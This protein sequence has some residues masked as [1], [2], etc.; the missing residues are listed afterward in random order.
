MNNS[1]YFYLICS[2]II[3]FLHFDIIYI[4]S[5]RFLIE[6]N[7]IL[8]IEFDKLLNACETENPQLLKQTTL[9]IRNIPIRFN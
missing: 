4:N 2:L 6:Y 1:N 3:L 9:M 7:I 5:N 8:E